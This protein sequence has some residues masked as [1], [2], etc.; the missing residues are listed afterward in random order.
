[1]TCTNANTIAKVCNQIVGDRK[2]HFLGDVVCSNDFAKD[3]TLDKKVVLALHVGRSF[4][5]EK[6]VGDKLNGEQGGKGRKTSFGARV[7][8]MGERVTR[9]RKRRQIDAMST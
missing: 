2:Y 7:R 4:T 8:R 1:M 5:L 9:R 6:E 3:D